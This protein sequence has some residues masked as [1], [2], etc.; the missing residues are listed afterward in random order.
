MVV[1]GII[2]GGVFCQDMGDIVVSGVDGELQVEFRIQNAV[3]NLQNSFV[4][5]YY[6]DASGRITITGLPE[7]MEAYLEG[8]P[9][10]DLYNPH[11]EYTEVDGYVMLY[12]RF[13]QD[14]APV[15]SVSQKVYQANN[16]VHEYPSSYRYFLSRFRERTVYVDQVLSVSYI[17]RGQT[18]RAGVAYMQENGRSAYRVLVLDNSGMT[19]GKVC[20]HQYIPSDLADRCG[21]DE[22]ALLYVEFELGLVSGNRFAQLDKMRCTFD[23]GNH[24]ERTAFVFK[25]LFGVPETL[26]MTGQNKRTSEL[27]AT[28]SWIGRKYRKTSTDLMT[29]HTVCT[30]YIDD[31]THASVKDAIRSAEV[32]VLDGLELADQV[33][34]TDIDLDYTMP[35][36][37]PLAAYLTYRVSEKIQE[38]FSRLAA[39]EDEI[40]DDS[41]DDTFE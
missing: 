35:R 39:R 22:E 21:V 41:F 26:V 18:L 38:R 5:T 14:G 37:A 17:Y 4:E 30:G 9:L 31:A 16:R 28:F 40:F 2:E 15:D 6:P 10:A 36:T 32:Y 3:G 27:E 25:N 1:N 19:Q 34:V 24:L 7:L 23:H 13:S 20:V 33:T 12:L 8:V 29:S 11:Q